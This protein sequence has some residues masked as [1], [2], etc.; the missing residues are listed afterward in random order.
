MN[1]ERDW[2][3]FELD[4]IDFDV[5]GK[6]FETKKV[7]YIHFRTFARYYGEYYHRGNWAYLTGILNLMRALSGGKIYYL[8]DD[9]HIQEGA[10]PFEK[11]DQDELDLYFAKHEYGDDGD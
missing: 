6:S 11:A 8:M 1:E 2:E 4:D 3:R 5:E 10:M 9:E 7:P